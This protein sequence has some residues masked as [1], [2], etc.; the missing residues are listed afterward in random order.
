MTAIEAPSSQ[1]AGSI[2]ITN[3]TNNLEIDNITVLDLGLTF[4]IEG[5]T[6]AVTN[7][8]INLVFAKEIASTDGIVVKNKDGEVVPAA[9]ILADDNKTVTLKVAAVAGEYTVEVAGVKATDATAMQEAKTF[10][11]ITTEG[12]AYS[13]EVVTAEGTATCTI[14][15]PEV[16]AGAKLYIATYDVNGALVSVD[17]AEITSATTTVTVEK[18]NTVKTFLWNGMKPVNY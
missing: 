17:S 10:G 2:A 15:H 18:A 1:T 7:D 16:L 9:L 11:I 14:S 12:E 3:G 6:K 8:G 5:N 4:A 13:M